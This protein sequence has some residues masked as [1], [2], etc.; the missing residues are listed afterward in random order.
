MGKIKFIL[1][2]LIGVILGI[3]VKYEYDVIKNK[4]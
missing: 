4:K 3:F 1:I 2:L